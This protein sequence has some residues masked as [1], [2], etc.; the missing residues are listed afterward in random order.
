MSF[1]SWPSFKGWFLPILCMEKRLDTSCTPHFLWGWQHLWN[2][3]PF[4]KLLCNSF[5]YKRMMNNVLINSQYNQLP[6]M[7]HPENKQQKPKTMK[8]RIEAN[9]RS[10]MKTNI[11]NKQQKLAHWFMFWLSFSIN[12]V[13]QLITRINNEPNNEMRILQFVCVDVGISPS[14]QPKS[15]HFFALNY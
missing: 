9:N 7:L 2:S 11:T 13:L 10:N 15:Y 8:L 4:L 3:F 5:H 6:S 14:L 12:Q 1:P